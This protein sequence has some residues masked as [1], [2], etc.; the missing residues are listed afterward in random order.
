[1]NSSEFGQPIACRS[2]GKGNWIELMSL[3]RS[4]NESY[5]IGAVALAM[6]LSAGAMQTSPA[7]AEL[8]EAEPPFAIEAANLL[9]APGPVVAEVT[10]G[11][12]IEMT[13]DWDKV[14]RSRVCIRGAPATSCYIAEKASPGDLRPYGD[15]TTAEIVDL[16]EGHTAILFQATLN[17]ASYKEHLISLLALDAGGRL[18][19]ILPPF[20]TS[21]ASEFRVWRDRAVSPY[22][23]VS[24]AYAVM[25]ARETR[26]DDH[27]FRIITY[28]FCPAKK[29]FLQVAEIRTKRTYPMESE[30]SVL[31][32]EMPRVRRGLLGRASTKGQNHCRQRRGRKR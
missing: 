10:P 23:I 15:H 16:G 9:G 32:V 6:M 8:T 25:T 30:Q 22:P 7:A 5:L 17:G 27:R 19:S 21:E 4:V 11:S 26:W 13:S 24:R 1:M 12:P 3:L 31:G 18:A 29:Q 2:I 20:T 14:V 28:E